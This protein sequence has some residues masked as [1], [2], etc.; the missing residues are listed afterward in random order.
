MKGSSRFDNHDRPAR[1]HG[2]IEDRGV[3]M[4]RHAL[5]EGFG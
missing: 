3:D 1:D 4:Q 5:D 2:D